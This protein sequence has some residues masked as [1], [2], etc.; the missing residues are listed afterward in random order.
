MGGAQSGPDETEVELLNHGE[1]SPEVCKKLIKE[2]YIKHE[3]NRKK[4]KLEL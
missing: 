2:F 3:E 4:K 1:N